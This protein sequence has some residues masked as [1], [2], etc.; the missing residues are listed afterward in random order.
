[1]FSGF[2]K[3]IGIWGDSI[4]KGVVFDD[5]KAGYSL[6]KESCV[7]IAGRALGLSVVNRSRF[8]STV[9]KGR[10]MLEKAL[11]DGLDCDAVLLEY[12]GNDCDFN[13]AE[14]SADPDAP[15]EPNTPMPDFERDL[16]AMI[17]M[18]RAR[19]IEPVMMSLPPIH[20]E[21]YLDFLVERGNLDRTNMLR[22]LGDARRIYQY[23]EVYSLAA[24]RLAQYNRC[25]YIPVREEFLI[26][27]LSADLICSDGIHP[28][29]DGHRLMQEIFTRNGRRLAALSVPS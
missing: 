12:G 6:L 17:D 8:G 14:V 13:W 16:Q 1:M 27:R 3:T 9:G 28:N 29:E 19:E 4:L 26:T 18:L 15:H 21:R 25:A 20:G 24:T 7:Q 10:Q 2:A 5:I 11:A 23:Q 22:F